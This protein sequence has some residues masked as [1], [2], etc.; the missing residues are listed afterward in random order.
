MKQLLIA[1]TLFLSIQLNSQILT[2]TRHYGEV[3]T[4]YGLIRVRTNFYLK[5]HI[6]NRD[7]SGFFLIKANLLEDP[8]IKIISRPEA[9]KLHR[10]LTNLYQMTLAPQPQLNNITYHIT[11]G[12]DFSI[13]VFKDKDKWKCDFIY[14]LIKKEHAPVNYKDIPQIAEWVNQFIQGNKGSYRVKE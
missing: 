12:D 13:Q 7:T 1:I 5:Y 9:E 14:G 11:V 8:F 2:G 3:Y 4:D 10:E 6:E